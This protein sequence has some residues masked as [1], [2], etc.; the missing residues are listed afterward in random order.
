MQGQL[1]QQHIEATLETECDHC[2]ARLEMT[3][4]SDLRLDVL[5]PNAEPLVFE[6][7]ID[8]RNFGAPNILDAY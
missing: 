3:M 6:P 8:W 5:T 4:T 1:R 2:G 7:E